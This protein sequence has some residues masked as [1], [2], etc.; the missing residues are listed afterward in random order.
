MD[1][2]LIAVEGLDGCGKAT[3][4]ERLAQALRD[5]GHRVATATFP[6]YDAGL[7]GRKVGE[8]LDGRLGRLPDDRPWLPALLFAADRFE[9]RD[10]LRRQR[11]ASDFLLVDR[12]VASNIAFQA[13][14]LDGEKLADFAG[15]LERLEFG[16][17]ALPR[18]DLQ[19]YLRMPPATARRL[20][21]GKSKRSYTD[22]DLD[23]YEKDLDRQRRSAAIYEWLAETGFGGPWRVVDGAD[24]AGEPRSRGA[25]TG[26][27]LRALSDLGAD[28]RSTV[29]PRG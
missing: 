8:Y 16:V 28:A 12:Y 27:L 19:L 18:P 15:W 29:S 10:R 7:I 22:R 2:R 23:L 11:E 24:E 26:D 14:R 9:H 3:Q 25:I 13:V 21:L 5:A 17:F 20:V 6:S 1:A 4:V